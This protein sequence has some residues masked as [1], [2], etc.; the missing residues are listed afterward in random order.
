MTSRPAVVVAAR[1]AEVPDWQQACET[2]LLE[3]QDHP[4]GP[5]D[6]EN[7]DAASQ[8][9][10]EPAPGEDQPDESNADD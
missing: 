9:A 5:T 2:A 4:S 6:A 7:A 1:F 3:M 8:A 10:A